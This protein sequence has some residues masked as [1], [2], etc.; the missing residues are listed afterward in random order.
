MSSLLSYSSSKIFNFTK[1][2]KKIFNKFLK[3]KILLKKLILKKKKIT[4]SKVYYL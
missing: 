2:K 4:T 1:K 3:L